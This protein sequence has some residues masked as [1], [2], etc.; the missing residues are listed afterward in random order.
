MLPDPSPALDALAVSVSD[1][2][3]DIES[4]QEHN[5]Q[6]TSMVALLTEQVAAVAAI[7][8]ALSPPAPGSV[9]SGAMSPR[10]L[11]S[12]DSRASLFSCTTIIAEMPLGGIL[13]SLFPSTF[14]CTTPHAEMPLFSCTNHHAETPLGNQNEKKNDDFWPC[15]HHHVFLKLRSKAHLHI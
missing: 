14:S 5:V 8:P 11:R 10:E 7:V 6:L 9:S 15:V 4:L 2:R 12:G 13:F 1:H 3:F